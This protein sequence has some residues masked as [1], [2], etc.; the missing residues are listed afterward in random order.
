MI[1]S[2]ESERLDRLIKN[3]VE[4]YKKLKEEDPDN[5]ALLY[6]N[7]EITF[8]RDSIMPI[9][10]AETTVDY[11]EIRNFVTRTIRSLENHPLSR[12]TTDVILHI[13]L[14]QPES[15]K[16]PLAAIAQ[17]HDKN[18]IDAELYVNF[19]LAQQYSLPL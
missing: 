19:D 7:S 16:K 3:K 8:L 10:L 12:R 6:L 13:H 18:E 5:P 11:S 4:R 15:G 1:N 14:K 9:V 17:S 2:L